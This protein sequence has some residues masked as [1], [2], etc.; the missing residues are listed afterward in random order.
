MKEFRDIIKKEV[1]V[2]DEVSTE[3]EVAK[4]LYKYKDKTVFFERIKNYE[5]FKIV[6]NIFTNR[7]RLIEALGIK[8][9]C[10]DIM[11][12]EKSRGKI[13]YK[14][15]YKRFELN[16]LKK[17]PILKHFKEDAG[18]YITSGVVI[19]YD[20]D[21]GRN[22]SIHRLLVLDDEHLAI[23]LVERDL[24]RYYK[25]KEEKNEPLEIVICIG[26]NP[27]VLFS[28]CY[29]LDIN[30]DEMEFAASF[31]NELYLTKAKTV[32]LDYPIDSEIVIEGE[33]LP[34]I[35]KEEGPFVDIT[36]T[37]DAKRLQPVIKVKRIAVRE[38]PI[39]YAILPS[40]Y[41]HQVLMGIVKEPKIYKEVSKVCKVKNVA[42]TKGSMYYF[43][44]VISIEK[45]HEED[46][47]KAIK[48][49]FDAH[50]GLKLVII[51]DED[52]DVYNWE[53][54]E[55][56]LATRFQA[57]KKLYVFEKMPGSSLDPSTDKS[58]ITSKIGIDATMP[59]NERD[60]YRR[61]TYI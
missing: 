14:N 53:D 22:A 35:R 33:I 29:S 23:R 37:Y 6:G 11:E 25:K 28:A 31:T 34:K 56:A 27:Y 60:K 38:N 19:A 57:N 47:L 52:I 46:V 42:M 17:L 2:K 50:K 5:N 59:I 32:N 45:K 15:D 40:G 55:Y 10:K 26:V 13:V 21:F 36:G 9:F 30:K 41:E 1:I 3:Y 24:Y 58:G 4:Y 18:R 48:A 51:V 54:V 44:C 49:A 39:Y 43:H 7:N 61:V 16:S 20:E 12:K 8:N